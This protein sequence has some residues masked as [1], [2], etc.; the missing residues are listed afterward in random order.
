MEK[1]AAFFSQLRTRGFEVFNALSTAQKIGIGVTFATIVGLI[2]ALA[3]QDGP[4]QYAYLYRDLASSDNTAIVEELNKMGTIDFIVDPKGIKVMPDQ[5]VPLR[6]KLAQEGLP[7]HGQIGWEKFDEQD[8]TRTEFE[9]NIHQL[10]AI[11]GE[12]SRTLNQLDGVNSSRVHIVPAKKSLFVEDQEEASAAIYIKVKRGHRLD[13]KIINGIVHLTAKSVEGLRPENVTII[14]QEGK[15]LTKVENEDPTGKRQDQ[16]L[17]YKRSREK[18]MTDKVRVIVS[19]IVGPERVDVKV[20]IDF[21]FTEEEQ[22]IN[23]IDPDKVVVLASNTT[24]QKMDG[25]GLNPT[26]IPGAK[27]NVPGEQQELSVTSSRA[28]SERN[29][30]RLNY[31]IAKTKKHR[32]M[33]VGTIKKISAAV[34]VDGLQPY[35]LD[36]SKPLFEPRSPDEMKKIEEIVKSTIGFKDGRD[37]VTV[38]NMVFELAPYQ[39][40][41]IKET[42]EENRNYIAT[43][44]VSATIALGLVLLF[45]FVVRPY[46]RWLSY[47]PE[48]KVRESNIEEFKPDL[49]MGSIQN[50]QV[51]EDVPFEKLSPQEQILFLAKNEPERTTEAIRLLLNPH[52]NLG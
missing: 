27:S 45:A 16:M 28:Q 42:K 50:V 25:N 36:G 2:I 9:Q 10:R 49:E 23:D 41:A 34:I 3:I 52:H 21:D 26:G 20:N 5:V 39:I 18:E 35:P 29:S 1:I 22:T 17:A 51:K 11:Q 14:D 40:E 30:E 38:E 13:S 44:A 47:D 12:I 33:P 19:R 6:L 32:L 48:R 37:T 46:F 7:S 24:N 43:L 4:K 31:E 8:F 15:M